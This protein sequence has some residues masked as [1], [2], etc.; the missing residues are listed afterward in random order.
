MS[1]PL[2]CIKCS[3]TGIEIKC[4]KSTCSSCGGSGVIN[5]GVTKGICGRCHGSGFEVTIEKRMCNH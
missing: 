5:A 1:N 3:G 2:T 4:R